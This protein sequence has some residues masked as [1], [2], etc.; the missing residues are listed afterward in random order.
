[1]PVASGEVS[2][3]VLRFSSGPVCVLTKAVGLRKP[4]DDELNVLGC[5]VDII[6]RDKL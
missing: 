4:D 2:A 6:I 1:M 5:R 3:R